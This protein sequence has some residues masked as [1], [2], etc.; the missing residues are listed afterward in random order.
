L[1]RARD[2]LLRSWVG[3]VPEVLDELTGQERNKIYRMLHL[4]VTPTTEGFGVTGALGG[5]LHSETDA[6]AAALTP[7]VRPAG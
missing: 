3:A 7:G 1:E 4:E 6:T 2:A 5:F